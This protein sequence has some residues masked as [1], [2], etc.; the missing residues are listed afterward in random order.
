[1]II[2]KVAFGNNIEAYIE[3]RLENRVNIIFSDDN[4][5]GK[6]LVM[7]GLMYS[8]GYE[9]IF[10][11]T[12]FYKEYYFYSKIEIDNKIFEFVRK[13]NLFVI[14]ENG[15]VRI[16]DS[17]AEYKVYFSKHIFPLPRI[18]KDN[19]RRMVDLTLFYEIFF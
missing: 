4:N 10:P 16:F 9:S 14:K 15:D 7:Q 12:F 1:M 3:N 13:K 5:K 17:V 19:Q 11:S 6:T 8:L 18:I 2:K